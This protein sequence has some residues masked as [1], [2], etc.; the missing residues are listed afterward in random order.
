MRIII[1]VLRPF[2]HRL[3]QT[4]IHD[5]YNADRNVPRS[6]K[7][8]VIT[9]VRVKKYNKGEATLETKKQEAS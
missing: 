7:G 8:T 6:K 3:L 9:C 2:L 5:N 4:A 1:D